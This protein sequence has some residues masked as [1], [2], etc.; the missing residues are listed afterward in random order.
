MRASAVSG[1]AGPDVST[2]RIDG[3]PNGL[4][5]VPSSCE[6]KCRTT[7]FTE[8]TFQGR[9]ASASVCVCVC[10]CVFMCVCLCVYVRV[11]VCVC[12]CVLKLEWMGV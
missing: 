11:S 8:P 4:E 6:V 3:G 7:P 1:G 10:V 9:Y 12:L 5:M 2:V